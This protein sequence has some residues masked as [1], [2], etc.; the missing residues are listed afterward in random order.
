MEFINNIDEVIDQ[1]NITKD[2]PMFY[3]FVVNKDNSIITQFNGNF[4]VL[5]E[6]NM[7][8]SFKNG[9]ENNSLSIN[10]MERLL[11]RDLWIKKSDYI[12]YYYSN[13]VGKY[14]L[15]DES[16]DYYLGMLE[17]AIYYLYD[18]AGYQDV[19]YIEHKVFDEDNY[20]NPLN[21][22]VDMKERDYAEYLKYLFF[23][24]KYKKV[25]VED[26]I[27]RY[28]SYYNYDLVIARLLFPNFYF[29]LFDKVVLAE[30]NENVLYDV[31]S[32]SSEYEEYL[33]RIIKCVSSFFEIKKIDWLHSI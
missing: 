6:D 25:N 3:K 13:I 12:E 9:I 29:N 22:K 33:K 21:V 15:I 14:E 24:N 31:I 1:Y 27:I 8:E 2:Y 18:Y 7:Q 4:L 30:E 16:I 17:S 19:G 11:W 32:R 20:F 10:K 28:K 5:L 26:L 23:S